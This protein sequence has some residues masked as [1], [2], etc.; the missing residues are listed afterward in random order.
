MFA[1][2]TRTAYDSKQLN[3]RPNANQDLS[4]EEPCSWCLEFFLENLIRIFQVLTYNKIAD[5][6]GYW[7]LQCAEENV[8][9]KKQ[10]E[11]KS[12]IAEN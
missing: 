10:A 7:L 5:P 3:N 1:S 4:Y 8:A 12:A 6:S 2:L 9:W 11:A